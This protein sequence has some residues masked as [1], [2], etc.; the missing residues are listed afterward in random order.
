L[1]LRLLF[2]LKSLIELD[3]RFKIIRFC[4]DECNH[5]VVFDTCQTFVQYSI[6]LEELWEPE[7]CIGPIR[8]GPKLFNHHLSHG[9]VTNWLKNGNDK[10][11][12]V[13]GSQV[14][15]KLLGDLGF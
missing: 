1:V 8:I 7:R 3:Q 2:G 11:F 5:I 9:L 15:E 12:L 14:G 13:L 10:Q 6:L 4:T